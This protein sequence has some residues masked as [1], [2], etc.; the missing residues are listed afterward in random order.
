MPNKVIVYDLGQ[1]PTYKRPC[2]FLKFDYSEPT[3][4]AVKSTI[5]SLRYGYSVRFFYPSHQAGGWLKDLKCWFVDCRLWDEFQAT[6][7]Q[8]GYFFYSSVEWQAHESYY[9]RQNNHHNRSNDN[10]YQ[11]TKTAPAKCNIFVDWLKIGNNNQVGLHTAYKDLALLL[12]PDRQQNEKLKK[13]AE[14][15]MKQ[16][17]AD[18]DE[19]RK[20]KAS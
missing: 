13:T 10:N 15:L 6:M 14:D 1:H 19:F 20:A 4:E 5:N 12:H 11:H 16:I 9:Q 18:F 3:I 7:E 17:N 8:D 2:I